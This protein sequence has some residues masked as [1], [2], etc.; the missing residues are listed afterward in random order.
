M[1][2]LFGVEGTELLMALFDSTAGWSRATG[3]AEPYAP[4]GDLAAR[5]DRRSTRR[6]GVRRHGSRPRLSGHRGYR[7]IQRSAGSARLAAVFVAEIGDVPGSPTAHTVLVGRADPAP[8]RIRHPVHRGQITKQ[9]SK[10]VRWA[11]VEAAGRHP[12]TAKISADKDR[13]EAPPRKNIAKVAAARKLL[14]L[15]YY[16]LRDGHIRALAPTPHPDTRS[17]HLGSA[18]RTG[19]GMSSQHPAASGNCDE[20]RDPS[21]SRQLDAWSPYRLTPAP[22]AARSPN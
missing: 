15:V 20:L 21:R 12:T 9:G 13:I 1:S 10:L 17:R 14:T 19:R 4:P 3:P 22:R 8:P 16:G 5:A 6:R 7:A 11:A 2:D 18:R